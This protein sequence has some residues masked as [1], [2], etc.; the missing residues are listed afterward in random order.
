MNYI[1]EQVS[2]TVNALRLEFIKY[3]QYKGIVYLDRDG[4]LIEDHGYVGSAKKVDL[5]NGSI[6]FL[7]QCKKKDYII[8][9]ITNQSGIGRGYYSWKDYYLVT[10][11]ML[12][13]F[14]DEIRPHFIVACSKNPEDDAGCTDMYRKPQIGMIQYIREQIGLEISNE[15]LIGDKASDLKCGLNADIKSISHVLTGHGV[16]EKGKVDDLRKFYPEISVYRDI[17]KIKIL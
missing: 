14:G 2:D 9:I 7:Q 4:V 17:G 15:L 1:K 16:T 12:K 13:K 6:S 8:A 11:E 5:I 3:D 10:N